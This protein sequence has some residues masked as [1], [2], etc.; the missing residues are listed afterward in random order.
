MSQ[1]L[2][3][4]KN[5]RASEYF[6][7]NLSDDISNFLIKH[8]KSFIVHRAYIIRKLQEQMLIILKNRK[9]NN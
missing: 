6:S 8:D 1:I 2:S 9:R 5:L 4:K 7:D 3:N